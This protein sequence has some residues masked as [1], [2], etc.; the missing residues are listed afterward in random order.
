MISLKKMM[1]YLLCNGIFLTMGLML[2]FGLKYHYS[3]AGSDDL[4]WILN[5]TA[6]LV[7]L[8][9]GIQFEHETNTGFVNRGYRTI[10][11]PSCAGINFLIVAFCMALFSGIHSIKRL[12]AK[13]SWL[14]MSFLSA[15][16]LTLGVN[17]IR[18]I[19]SIYSCDANI[20][21]GW[22]TPQRV[23][24]LEGIVI[25]FFFLCLFYM[26]IIKVVEQITSNTGIKKQ[27][28]IRNQSG[29]TDFLRWLWAGLIP[30]FWYSLVTIGVPLLNGALQV[31][32]TRFTEHG[33]MV[34]T[35]SL[36]V[37]VLVF[38]I[39]LASKRFLCAADFVKS[40]LEESVNTK[41]EH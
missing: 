5:P 12:W 19:V 28:D 9:S 7:E 22:L 14:T 3:R 16:V 39:R 23:H 33:G 11:A 20:Y 41:S 17:T 25:Y 32:A 29:T 34:L 35:A 8:V 31:N 30:L 2:A 37:M 10:I 13:L 6:G 38:S 26:I 18:I 36:A 1:R 27:P 24:R 21:L 15:Y 4:L 40:R